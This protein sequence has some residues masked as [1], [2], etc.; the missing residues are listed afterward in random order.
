MIAKI[1]FG[2]FSRSLIGVKNIPEAGCTADLQRIDSRRDDLSD[3]EEGY[4]PL[5]EQ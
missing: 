1:A 4:L 5:T 2:K 3:I